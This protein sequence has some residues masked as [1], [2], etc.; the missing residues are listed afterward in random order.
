MRNFIYILFVVGFSLKAQDRG[1]FKVEN[2]Q[3][4]W[5][6]IYHTSLSEDQ[7]KKAIQADPILNPMAADLS[8]TSNPV[9]VDCN[10]SLPIYMDG[11]VQYFGRI[12]VKEGRYRITVSNI[13]IIPSMTISFMGARSGENP[14]PLE[15]YQIRTRDQQLK[16]NSLA[17]NTIGCLDAYFW[18][19]FAFRLPEDDW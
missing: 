10:K 11:Q 12:E 16:N 14:T 18:K 15:T 19:T 4:V 13:N 2:G 8:G 7:I 1:N 3:I 17:T 9:K 6:K 5:Q